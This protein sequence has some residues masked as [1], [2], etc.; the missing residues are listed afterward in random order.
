MCPHTSTL[1]VAGCVLVCAFVYRYVCAPTSMYAGRTVY[2]HALVLCGSTCFSSMCVHPPLCMCIVQSKAPNAAHT[3]AC[4]GVRS[5]HI[6]KR[7]WV[8]DIYFVSLK[9]LKQLTHTLAREAVCVRSPHIFALYVVSAYIFSICVVGIY[10]PH[11]YALC[12]RSPHILLNAAGCSMYTFVAAL[13]Q[14]LV[15]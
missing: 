2:R 13:L 5:P 9:H 4:S 15:R 7:S 6:S 1:E 11:I 3:Y 12:V 8:F 14:L 10:I